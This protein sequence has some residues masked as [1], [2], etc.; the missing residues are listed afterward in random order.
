M[1]LTA[2]ARPGQ[3]LLSHLQGVSDRMEQLCPD[4]ADWA[5]LV[6]LLHDY[7]KYRPEWVKGIN[8][9]ATGKDCRLP[10]HAVEGG[11]YLIELFPG[12]AN[13]KIRVLAL[14]IASHHSGLPDVAARRDWLGGKDTARPLPDMNRQQW[15]IDAE[16]RTIVKQIASVVNYRDLNDWLIPGDYRTAQ[17]LRYLY[18]ALIAADRQ[19]AATSDGWEPD[20][21]PSMAILSGKL[22][23][24][25]DREFSTPTS[26]LNILRSDFYA[27]CRAAAKLTPGWLAVR[28]ACGIS[29]TWSV[30]QMALDHAALWDKQKVI[31]CVPWS[32][33]LEQ[34]YE[35]YQALL[36][37]DNVLG[38]WSTL[39]DPDSQN[40]QQLRNSRQWWEA[41]I[42][43]TTMVQ[44]FD[45]LLGSTARTA[46]RMPSLRDAVII[47]DEVQGLPHEL[48][49][50]CIKLLDQLV[51]DFGV[52]IILT[53]ATM[54][55][56]S[57]LGIIPTEAL[58]QS[59]VD[60]YFRETK[61]VDYQWA[62]IPLSWEAI[63]GEI[64]LDR[65]SSTL[66]VTNTVAACNDA[67]RVMTLVSGCRVYKYTA[68][69]TPAHRSVVLAEIKLA[70][71]NAKNGGERV[72]ICGTSAIETGVDLDCDR[73][74]REWTGLDSIVQFAGRIN[75]NQAKVIC[76][77]TIFSTVEK[78]SAPLGFEGRIN[79]T[80]QAMAMGTDLHSPDVMASYSKRLL[81]DVISSD[82]SNGAYN[83]LEGLEKLEWETVSQKW[84]MISPTTPV[85][86][87]PRLWN[88]SSNIVA[89]YDE[90]V[91]KA[92]YRVLQRHC[93]GLSQG[94][95]YQAK[96][97]GYIGSTKGL[98]EWI[99]SYDLGLTNHLGL[100]LW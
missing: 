59:D 18:G 45:V 22:S 96:E 12:I 78:Y 63:A 33:I 74:Y 29:K 2:L 80:R 84:R 81:Q 19:D 4:L 41:P 79:R 28:G 97:A 40:P 71:E 55:D 95:Y 21:Y 16:Y 8:E 43:T 52:T 51:Q 38:H 50:T 30:M 94:K 11:L 13:I 24:W 6:G 86:V 54:L 3:L 73:G 42:V 77:V 34:S 53:T 64:D 61:R 35:Q 91:S 67:Y 65:Q 76:T 31:Y 7:G 87:D 72:I 39:V 10:H 26:P 57:P 93:V 89:E 25:Y 98:N 99:G 27:Q 90:A 62:E 60:R 17:R 82:K 56:Y 15:N 48:L 68:N 88:A 46:Q 23:A 66:I 92:N 14:L 49:I 58:S 36:G 44:L 5:K 69:M 75:R 100:L 83:Y 32:A 85:L 20:D 1:P 37:A 47:L 70:V 9:I